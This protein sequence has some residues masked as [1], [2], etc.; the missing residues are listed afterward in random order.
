MT[1][2][3]PIKNHVTKDD[4]ALLFQKS[5]SSKKFTVVYL[6]CGEIYGILACRKWEGDTRPDKK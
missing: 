1:M 2:K 6:D 5:S 4:Y 3:Y